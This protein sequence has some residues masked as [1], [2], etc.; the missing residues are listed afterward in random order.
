MIGAT[1]PAQHQIVVA[2]WTS[3]YTVVVVLVNFN[4]LCGFRSSCLN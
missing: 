4:V 3:I 2:I 1:T